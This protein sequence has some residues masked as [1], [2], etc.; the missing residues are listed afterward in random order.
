MG[1]V[2][3]GVAVDAGPWPTPEVAAVREL[4][5][6]RAVALGLLDGDVRDEAA[7]EAAVER[8]LAREVRVPAPDET[9]CRRYYEANRARF[10]SG[11]LVHLRHILFQV[12][13]GAPVAAIRARAEETLAAVLAEPERFEALARELSNCPSG[14][15]GGNLGQIGRGDTVPEF[16]RA[17]FEPGPTGIL[18]RLVKSRHG[19]HIVA[20]DRRIPGRTLPYEAVRERIAERLAAEVEARALRQYVAVLAGQAEI[21]G[22]DLQAAPTPLVQ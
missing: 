4:L 5:R 21:E 19:F 7:V 10:R 12:T 17:V 1:V 15:H 20:V 6:Q 3:N 11:D 18:R 22:A 9:A 14:Q 13:P 16:E 8:L 2:V